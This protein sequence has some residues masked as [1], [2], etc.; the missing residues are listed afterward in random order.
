LK[1]K[2]D[3]A[4]G[5]K[6][7]GN[8][9]FKSEN[10]Q[11]AIE[12]Y[13]DA[14]MLCPLCYAKERSIMYSN[15]AASKYKLVTICNCTPPPLFCADMSVHVHIQKQNATMLLG[16]VSWPEKTFIST[17]QSAYKCRTS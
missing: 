1:T 8:E 2:K 6:T 7:I 3:E 5:K 14:L 12:C 4:Q 15:R 13:T 17:V 11:G 10:Y 9:R 16:K